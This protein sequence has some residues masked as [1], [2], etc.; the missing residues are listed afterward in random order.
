MSR[1]H[2]FQNFSVRRSA[3]FFLKM[4]SSTPLGRGLEGDSASGLSSCTSPTPV[5]C[6]QV[7]HVDRLTERTNTRLRL[8]QLHCILASWVSKGCHSL[9][10]HNSCLGFNNHKKFPC[11]WYS[12]VNSNTIP[13]SSLSGSLR[14][15]GQ[16]GMHT[17]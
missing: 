11:R 17:S 8:I 6:S 2:F 13:S 12:T 4:A 15:V 14:Y 3:P 16:R 10:Q 5:S 1:G 7:L 9:G